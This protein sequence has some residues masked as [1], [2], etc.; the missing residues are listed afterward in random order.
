MNKIDDK[1]KICANCYYFEVSNDWDI[2]LYTFSIIKKMIVVKI[3][4]R[5]K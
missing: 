5:K 3:G 2:C 1:K 4:K